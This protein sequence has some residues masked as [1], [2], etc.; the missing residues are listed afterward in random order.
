MAGHLLKGGCESAAPT[1]PPLPPPGPSL[2]PAS[3]VAF[4]SS[5]LGP[6]GVRSRGAGPGTLTER[7][8]S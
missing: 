6:H 5:M 1:Q 7:G 2:F 4:P 3:G 8:A